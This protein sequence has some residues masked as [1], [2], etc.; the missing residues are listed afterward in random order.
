MLRATREKEKYMIFALEMLTAK[1]ENIIL[2]NGK[3]Y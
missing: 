1:W 2:I 3:F